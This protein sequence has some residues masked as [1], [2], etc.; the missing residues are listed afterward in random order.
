M[1]KHVTSSR[2]QKFGPIDRRY[3]IWELIVDDLVVFSFSASDDG[4]IEF[5]IEEAAVGKIFSLDQFK[6]LFA[7]GERR[8]K[9][10]VAADP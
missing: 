1:S 4:V 7:E 9:A 2:W 5:A 8:I 3:V 6:E 10:E